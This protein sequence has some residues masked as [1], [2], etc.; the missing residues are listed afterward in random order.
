MPYASETASGPGFPVST[1]MIPPA[2]SF[3]NGSTGAAP[4][5]TEAV[6]DAIKHAILA[7]ELRP[8]QGLVE[9]E[10][11]QLLG[12][13]KTPVREALKTLAGAGLVT[14]SPYRGATVRA[15][16]PAS[17][18]AIYD[19]RVL[20]E[21]EAVRRAV[22][23]STVQASAVQAGAVQAGAVQ[24]GAVQADGVQ[25]GAGRPD[26]GTWTAAQAALAAADAAADRA[27]RSL[28]NREFHRTL[29][30]ACGNSLLVKVLDDLRDQTALVSVLSWEQGAS[31]Q[32]EAA[33]HRAILAAARSGAAD[34][35]A[36]LLHAHIA[37][38]AGRHFP[39]PVRGAPAPA[40][41]WS[42]DAD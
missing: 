12:V 26:D 41:E 32:Q 40:T 9:T 28:A 27:Q 14:M 20:L 5:R 21:P 30:L 6:L 19:L 11:A 4:S 25:A 39:E 13:S 24:A 36:A 15:I 33:E 35:A 22:Q 31:W 3:L 10:L 2:R 38:F 7:G 37:G 34:E 1:A 29:Y 17:A 16:D 18:A 42:T 23:D 8:G